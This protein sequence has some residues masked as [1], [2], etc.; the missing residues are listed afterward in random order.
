MGSD[1]APTYPQDF[2]DS[3]KGVKRHMEAITAAASAAGEE[4]ASR[5]RSLLSRERS[6]SRE[7]GAEAEVG[8]GRIVA[9]YHR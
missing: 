9:L 3:R 5:G 1:A 8:L 2:F 4:K 7:R 6:A